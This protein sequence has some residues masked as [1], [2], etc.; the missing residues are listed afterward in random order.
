MPTAQGCL[1]RSTTRS[2]REARFPATGRSL[3]PFLL[4]RRLQHCTSFETQVSNIDMQVAGVIDVVVA[5]QIIIARE[6]WHF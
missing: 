6:T 2:T 1:Y 5:R 3:T 4:L